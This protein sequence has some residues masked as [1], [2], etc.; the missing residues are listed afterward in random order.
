MQGTYALF[1][2]KHE[3]PRELEVH[4]LEIIS[5]I[6]FLSAKDHFSHILTNTCLNSIY[7]HVSGRQEQQR[8]G[9]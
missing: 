5:N 9:V 2:V 1:L 4:F 6:F 3:K 8:A 7:I